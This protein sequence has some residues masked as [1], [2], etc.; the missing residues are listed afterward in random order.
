MAWTTTT[1][2][3]GG[4]TALLWRNPLVSSGP[5]L[6]YCHGVGGD[7]TEFGLA[8]YAGLRSWLHDQGWAALEANGGGPGWGNQTQR[9]TYRAAYDVVAADYEVTD[10]IVFGRSM[11]GIIGSWL[12][13]YD[14]AISAKSKGLIL[15]GAVQDLGW[16]YDATFATS[17][18]AAYGTSDRTSTMTAVAGHNP[19]DFPAGDYAGSSILFQAGDADTI[20]SGADNVLAQHTRVSGQLAFDVVDVE[21][22]GDHYTVRT[23]T[24]VHTEFIHH[25][26]PR[27]LAP[28][29]YRRRSN[30]LRCVVGEDGLLYPLTEA[31]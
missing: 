28:G 17:I 27:P 2:T 24:T 13:L 15:C 8:D 7:Q 14:P 29:V 18:R 31:V 4:D 3:A 5:L 1:F 16:A 30:S 21:P 12:H 19:I 20:V 11:G 23:R 6:I 9:D 10:V 26:A 25:V 22:G